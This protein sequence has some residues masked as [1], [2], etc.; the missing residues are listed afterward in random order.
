MVFVSEISTQTFLNGKEKNLKS[1]INWNN[2]AQ[3]LVFLDVEEKQ[4][5]WPPLG[6]GWVY[7]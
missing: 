5:Q 1:I 3:E 7:G 4:W 6:E 2:L